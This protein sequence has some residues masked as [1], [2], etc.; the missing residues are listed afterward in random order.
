MRGLAVGG[1]LAEGEVV[2][3]PLF[4]HGRKCIICLLPNTASWVPNEIISLSFLWLLNAEQ[5]GSLGQSEGGGYATWQWSFE[6]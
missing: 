5:V 4:E 2:E 1:G 3:G 6:I